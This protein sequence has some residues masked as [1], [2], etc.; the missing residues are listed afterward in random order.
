MKI[1]IRYPI[2]D[3]LHHL[4]KNIVLILYFLHSLGQTWRNKIYVRLN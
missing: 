4:Q 2:L 1:F 3:I